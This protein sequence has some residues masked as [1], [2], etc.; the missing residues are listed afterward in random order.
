M[1]QHWI[2]SIK[3]V[4]SRARS[5]SK[6]LTWRVTATLTTAVIAFFITGELGTAV[7]IGSI[8]FFMKFIIYYVHER[9]WLK[10]R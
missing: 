7:A 4:D 2:D 1:I 10:V 3:D 5:V 9:L 6:A 8:E